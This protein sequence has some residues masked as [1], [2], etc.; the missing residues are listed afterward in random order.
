MTALRL[1]RREVLTL[2]RQVATLVE[3]LRAEAANPNSSLVRAEAAR[4]R[5]GETLR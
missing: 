5:Q 1:R 2:A 4:V 3:R